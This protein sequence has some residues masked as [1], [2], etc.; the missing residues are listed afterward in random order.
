MLE[1]QDTYGKTIH[2]WAP[3]IHADLPLGPRKGI[4]SYLS[5]SLELKRMLKTA[6][7][8]M[9]FTGPGQVDESKVRERDEKL[10]LSTEAKRQLRKEYLPRIQEPAEGCDVGE[11]T[12]RSVQF[13]AKEVDMKP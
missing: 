7:L 13:I 6:N 9:S 4:F 5:V 8:M 2:T 12:G 11:K 1:L 3:D 10:G